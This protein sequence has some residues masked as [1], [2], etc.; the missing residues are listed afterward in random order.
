MNSFVVKLKRFISDRRTVSII[1]VIAGVVV[2]YVGYNMRVSQ[3][4]NPQRVPYAKNRLEARHIITQ[5]D[6]GIMEVSNSVV[7]KST[8]LI[9]DSASLIGK[10][11][12]YGNFISQGSLFY[13]EDVTSPELSPDYVLSDIEDCYTAFSL[14]V[15]ALSTYGNNILKDSYID[16]WFTGESDN[17][18]IYANLIK[19]IKVL[20]VRDSSGKSLS[21]SLSSGTPAELLFAVPDSM[22]SLLVKAESIGDLVPVPRNGN[23]TANPGE[24]EV[25]SEFIENLILSH[26]FT[27]PDQTDYKCL[28]DEEEESKEEENNKTSNESTNNTNNTNNSNNNVVIE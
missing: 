18:I 15:D 8:N 27:I 7:S 23:Y 13:T 3:T 21:N 2:L 11:V 16:L 1:C 24:T 22:Y 12:T 4:I 14:S 19:S 17:K 26:T 9:T 5:D 10:E 28:N 20:D 6:I 25:A